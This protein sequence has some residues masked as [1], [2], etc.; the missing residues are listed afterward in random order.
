MK[1]DIDKVIYSYLFVC[2]MLLIYNLIYIS[3]S[4]RGK[5]NQDRNVRA[6][7]KEVKRQ[8]HKLTEGESVEES[9]K[10]K[11]K[12]QLA[13]TNHLISY[14][15]ALDNLREKGVK[16]EKYLRENYVVIQGLA[17]QYAKKESMDKA[18][19][20]YFIFKNPPQ[21]GKEYTPLMEI[22]ISFMNNSTVY[23]RENVLNAL[24]SLGNCQ[25][26]E[27][28][29][30]IINENQWF[31]HRKLLS[32]GLMTF[33]GDKDELAERLWTYR[34]KW[35]DNLVVSVI[36]FITSNLNNFDERF[37][38]LLKGEEV[39]VEI[40]LAI[41]RYFRRYYYEP[42]EPILL[43]YL[44]DENKIDENM[45]I[46]AASV[47]ERYP[48]E[49]TIETLKAALHDSNWYLRYNAATSLVNLNVDIRNIRD[50][51]GGKDRYAKE[52]LTYMISQHY[53]IGQRKAG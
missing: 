7:K 37:L 39:S 33:N 13:N 50:V 47:L 41:M 23:C 15:R 1:F 8:L 45:K 34:K 43:A 2:F 44:K 12:K 18:F 36:Q 51:L 5:K 10:A 35:D 26:V 16:L 48:S 52:I 29:F 49:E 53:L 22:L 31:H 6:W 21:N 30:Q 25:G 28:A 40:K 11:L 24:Y 9:H 4:K 38:E 42:V 14:V 19:F 17:Y 32:D 46:V 20:A 3:N 27:N